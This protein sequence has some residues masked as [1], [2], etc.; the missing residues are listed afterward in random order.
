[1][2]KL[3]SELLEKDFILNNR[4]KIDEKICCIY[5]LIKNSEIVYI[6]QSTNGI[7][8]I[9]QHTDKDFDSYFILETSKEHLNDLESHYIVKFNPVYNKRVSYIPTGLINKYKIFK[10]FKING[11]VFKIIES[12]YGLN[13]I[14]ENYYSIK[15]IYKFI[16]LGLE[17]ENF[18]FDHKKNIVKN[19]KIRLKDL[20]APRVNKINCNETA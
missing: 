4:K 7:S 10:E 2:K 8:R 18:V 13:P 1:M 20:V 17:N 12:F 5:F 3:K 6:G 19:P 11:S 9:Q 16:E 15:E 14:Y